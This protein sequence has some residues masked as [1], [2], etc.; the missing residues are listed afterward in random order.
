MSCPSDNDGSGR[1]GASLAVLLSCSL[2][3]LS[4]AGHTEDNPTSAADTDDRKHTPFALDGLAFKGD[5]GAIGEPPFSTD[6]WIF[7]KGAVVSRECRACGTSEYWLR[8]DDGGLRFRAEKDCADTG[9]TLSYKGLVKDDRIEG[10]LTWTKDRWYG[11][12]EEKFRFVGERI[13]DAELTTSQSSSSSRSCGEV[14]FQRPGAG[15]RAPSATERL[16]R[17][18]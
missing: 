18:P 11:D 13:A 8:P 1:R 16:F 9:V 5:I 3:V 6:V 17:F 2:L 4:F 14:P 10:T 7:E 15:Q 12:I